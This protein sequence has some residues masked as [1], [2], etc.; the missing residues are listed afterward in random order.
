MCNNQRVI[1]PSHFVGIKQLEMYGNFQGISL[2]LR[3]WSLGW[4]YDM[5]HLFRLCEQLLPEVWRTSTYLPQSLWPIR[6][7]DQALSKPLFLS[8]G[9]MLGLG[10]GRLTSHFSTSTWKNEWVFTPFPAH[11]RWEMRMCS[12]SAYTGIAQGKVLR[13]ERLC[14]AK[15]GLFGDLAK[16]KVSH[17]YV[18]TPFKGMMICILYT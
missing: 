4:W 9:V 5:T 8:G 10:G 12:L 14:L 18:V 16:L 7:D 1:E 15:C 13:G 17:I 11:Q 3:A 6:H 2:K